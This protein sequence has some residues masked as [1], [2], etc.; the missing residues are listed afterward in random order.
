MK[1]QLFF[2]HPTVNII[3]VFIQDLFWACPPE[4]HWREAIIGSGNGLMSVQHQAI[5]STDADLQ[6]TTPWPY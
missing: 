2:F 1:F 3:F 4:S 5:S 6:W